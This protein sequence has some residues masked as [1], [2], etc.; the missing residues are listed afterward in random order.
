MNLNIKSHG[1]HSLRHACATYLINSGFSLKG[2]S[3][4]LGHQNIETTRIYAKVDLVNLHKVA[5]INWEDVL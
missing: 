5:D 4:Y 1:P 2:I 3:D